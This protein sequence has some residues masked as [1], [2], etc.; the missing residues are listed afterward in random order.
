MHKDHLPARRGARAALL[1]ATLLGTLP[2]LALTA[3]P[4]AAQDYTNVTASG[5]VESSEGKPIA[6]ATVEIT[7]N[8]RGFSRS[9]TTDSSGSYKFP[10]LA[11]GSYTVTVSAPEF[12]TYTEQHVMLTQASAAN[13]FTLAPANAAD[14][15]IVVKGGRVEVADFERT[16]TGAVVDIAELDKRV[17][18]AR[19]LRDIILLAPG[20]TQGSAANNGGFANQ[21]SISGSSFTEN[22]YYINGL[23]ITDFRLGFSP[24]TVPY[25]FLQ[26]VEV[27]TGGFPAEFGRATGGFVNATTKSG[28]NDF[29]GSVLFSWQPDALMGTSP[30]TFA[31][32]NDGDYRQSTD[33]IAQL[34]GPIIKDHLFF[35]G[36]Y[37]ARSSKAVDGTATATNPAANTA[38]IV[39]SD[40]PFWGGKL[41][42]IIIDGQHLE[43][44][45]FDTTATIHTRTF[46]YNS[47]TNTLSDFKG[48]NDQRTGGANWVGRYTGTFTPWLTLSAAYGINRKRD[49]TLPLDTT[50]ELI[51]DYRSGSQGTNIGLNT[52]DSVSFNDD[53][54]E[55]YRGD[56]DLYFSALGSHHVRFG[57]DHEKV[58]ATQ[59]YQTIG[60]GNLKYFKVPLAGDDT[61]LPAGTEYVVA[62]NYRNSGSFQAVNQAFYVEDSWSLL[63]DRLTLQLGLRNDRFDNRNAEGKT[64]WKSGNLW[65]PRLGF[66]FDP[67][68]DSKTKVYGSFGRYYLPLNVNMNLSFAGSVLTFNRYNILNGVN[69]GDG[70]PILGAPVGS[71][72]GVAACPDTGALNCTVARDGSVAD[73][74]NTFAHNLRA[75]SADEIILGAERRFGSNM[76]AGIYFTHRELRNALED[77]SIDLAARAYCVGKGFTDAACKGIYGGGSQFVIINPGK[78]NDITLIGLPDGTKPTVHFTA[79]Q[80]G[81][82]KPVRHFNSVTFTFDRAFDGVWG[83]SGSYTWA[84]TIGNYEGGAASDTGQV[85][86]GQTAAF[87]SPGLV[88]GTY[89]ELPGSRRHTLKLYGSY[90]PAEWLDFG[91]NLLV[92]SPRKYGCIGVVPTAVDPYAHGYGGYGFYCQ[93]KLVPRGSAFQSEWRKQIDV[94]AQVRVPA[95]FDAS[96]RLDV[97]NVFNFKSA[98][99]Y[100]EHGEFSNGQIE[101]TY[102]KPAVY[103][104][105]RTVR[106]QFR[107]GF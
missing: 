15:E 27:K 72:N 78:D 91:A 33:A 76:R 18:V 6:G 23:N 103:Q 74:T 95:T 68:G 41:D 98:I 71:V 77:S 36:L 9:G 34:S 86:S 59:T 58:T 54:R 47:D 89:G 38:S 1:A 29:H 92:Q 49:G 65:A 97:F 87:D 62:R 43:F 88:D 105:P 2:A 8:D 57:L 24:V 52:V 21:A 67:T 61:N 37:N 100:D 102:G 75:Q 22:A 104:D 25:D 64:Y 101:P 3:A 51:T 40:S 13:R 32:D 94:S 5:R 93:G 81:Y 44:T 90:R 70:T 84:K 55:F 50:H 73:T 106:L 66:T 11:P 14:G 79:A 48:G 35:Y 60:T 80:L 16:T 53:K 31:S 17:P 107:V 12:E 19:S 85:A 46:A 10:Q 28:S 99:D 7:S 4:A 39:T 83:I 69:P 56:A 20:T 42:A 63:Q 96:V 82:P 45:Y 26:T 30:N